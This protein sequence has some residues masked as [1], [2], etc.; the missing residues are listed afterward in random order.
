MA[1]GPG[2]EPAATEAVPAARLSAG[3]RLGR[4]ILLALAAAVAGV[5]PAVAV[6]T[7]LIPHHASPAGPC[8]IAG[9]PRQPAG[10][11]A[12]PES[13]TPVK[14]ILTGGQDTTL[15]FGR[16][17]G[18]KTLTLQ[19]GVG[20]TQNGIA[21]PVLMAG[22]YPRL[23]V[24]DPLGFSSADQVPIPGGQ[25]RALA[26]VQNDRVLLRICVQRESAQ[27]PPPGTYQGTVSIV[28]SRVE[29][30]DVPVTVTMSYPSWQWIMELLAGAVL[31]GTW[32]SWALRDKT[33]TN[34]ALGWTFVDWCGSMLGIL[35]IG[36]GTV[37][38]FGVYTAT[39]LNG[40]AWGSDVTQYFTLFGAMF[41]AFLAGAATVHIGAQAG[42]DTDANDKKKAAAGRAAD[43]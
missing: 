21:T 32:Y 42:R 38:A 30:V 13:Y 1:T 18:S 14:L 17:L 9:A 15:T 6:V 16:A 35:S 2:Q 28:D 34:S 41:S 4:V 24:A 43:G 23:Q 12:V 36:A 39:Y 37:A 27:Q 31:L 7:A 29:R 5:I 40:T 22:R 20:T 3:T 11:P 8:K 19:Y 10:I 26:W 33:S 25:V